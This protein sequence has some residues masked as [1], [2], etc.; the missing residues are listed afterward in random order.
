MKLRDLSIKWQL[1]AICIFLVAVPVLTL[2]ILSYQNTKK[3]T[4]DQIE[5]RL[6]QQAL[7]IKLLV[8]STFR[9]IDINRKN[10]DELARKIVGSQAEAI[11]KFISSWKGTTGDLDRIISSIRV[12]KSGYIWAMDY[13]GK[14]L[15][16]GNNQNIGNNLWN[17]TDAE[18]ALFFQEMISKARVLSE[19]QLAYH[20]YPWKNPGETVAR[21]KIAALIHDDKRSRVIGVSVYFDELVDTSYGE[22][23]I[24]NLKDKLAGTVVGKTGYIFI[25]DEKGNYVLSYGRERDGENIWNTKDANGSFFIQNIVSKALT[26]DLNET[27]TTYYPWQNKGESG[28][29]MKLASYAFFPEW[30]WVIAPSAYQGDFLDGLNSI[31][32][33]TIIICIV[34]ILMGSI[35]AYMFTHFMTKKFKDLVDKMKKISEGDLEITTDTDVGKNEIGMMNSAMSQMVTNLQGTVQ[36][37]G[38]IA[39]GNLMAKVN[40]LSEKDTLGQSLSS[41]VEKLGEVVGSVKAAADNVASGSQQLSSSS[42]EMSQGATEQ[43]S[44]AEEASSS[45]EEMAANI[46]QNADNAQQTEKIAI[47][48]AEDAKEGGNAVNET[49]SA[50]KEI[51]EKITII[52]EIARSTDLLALNAAIE[53]ARA[54]EHGKGFAVVASEVRKLAERSQTAA[55]EISRLSS[56]SVAV[57]ESAGEM[58]SRIVPDIQKTAELVQEISAASNE[59]STGADQI[60]KAILQLEQVIQQNASVSEEIASTSEELAS[61][62]EQL[63]DTISFF[64]VH[65]D[66]KKAMKNTAFKNVERKKIS[67]NVFA[68]DSKRSPE[69]NLSNSENNLPKVNQNSSGIDI[70]M[71][72]EEYH[73]DK[74]DSDFEKY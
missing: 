11:S 45:V 10:S 67:T 49:L 59:Q 56:S 35:I 72:E 74:Y 63:Q 12:G 46:R 14:L 3:E 7:Q 52:E 38:E 32:S 23:A 21:D 40:I 16:S 26:L 43:A 37:A 44:S 19:T 69:V 20:T 58:L 39:D 51:A 9:E 53:A 28:S 54:G 66:E 22:K 15:A 6:K 61:Q 50:M 2:G 27:A 5:S 73:L 60:N 17:S 1:L 24:E 55:G 13:N 62:A 65:Q 8:E 34:A 31:L 4:F 36:I 70:N 25:L 33:L 47:K 30:K 68:K 42:E 64:S 18:G 29:R 41:M 48:S 57:A 71:D